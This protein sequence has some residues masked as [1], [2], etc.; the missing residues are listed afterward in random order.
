MW[1]VVP[2][3]RFRVLGAASQKIPILALRKW[4]KLF[5]WDETKIGRRCIS[6]HPNI[7]KFYI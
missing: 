3:F 2:S 4:K 5:L 1:G 6:V 7:N